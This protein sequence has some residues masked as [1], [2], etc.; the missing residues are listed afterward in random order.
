MRGQIS[1]DYYVSVI[2]FISFVIYILFQLTRFLPTYINA[3]QDQRIRVEAY[4][5][6]ELLMND[7]GVPVDWENLS[8]DNL[9]QIQRIGLSD[10][11]QNKT[12]LVN[13][14]KVRSLNT[15]CASVNGYNILRGTMGTE[16]FFSIIMID[17]SNGELLVS[18]SPPEQF[19]RATKVDFRRVF[20]MGSND[21][22]ELILQLW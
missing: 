1:V 21:Y 16:Y 9:G 19:V 10:G 18:C 20:S 13:I 5:I 11:S 6:S 15:T 7:P 2:L 4:Q 14:K 17:K 8:E 22:G 3:V 12:N